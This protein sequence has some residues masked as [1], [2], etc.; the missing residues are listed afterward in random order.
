MKTYWDYSYQERAA[1]S[2][3]NVKSLLDVELMTKGVKKPTPPVLVEVPKSPVG[4]KQKFY[5]VVAKGKYGSDEHF[6]VCF[7]TIEAAQKFQELLPLRRDYDYEVGSEFE[8]VVPITGMALEVIELYGQEQI[9]EF[10]CELKSRKAK[11]ESNDQA[12]REFKKACEQS[13]SVTKHVWEDWCRQLDRRER[14][15]R[16]TKTFHEYLHLTSNDAPLALT[17][18][19]KA[20]GGDEIAE[21]RQW[22]PDSIWQRPELAE[23]TEKEAV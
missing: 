16:I 18:L 4:A 13:E 21:A 1:L 5:G 7:S 15:Q 14:L 10:R 6:G 17:F 23:A 8:Y 9:N 20:Y 12:T 19:E 3:E 2:E 11:T 22:F